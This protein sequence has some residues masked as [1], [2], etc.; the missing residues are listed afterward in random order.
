MPDRRN[1]KEGQRDMPT[2]MAEDTEIVQVSTR[3]PKALRQRLKVAAAV[4]DTSVQELMKQALEEY[5][6]KRD[7]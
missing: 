4:A 3:V 7:L 6:Q 2:A 1:E 5:L